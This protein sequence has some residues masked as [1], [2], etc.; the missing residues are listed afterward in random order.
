M[1]KESALR[2]GKQLLTAVMSKSSQLCV[3]TAPPPEG[4]LSVVH[5]TDD[6]MNFLEPLEVTDTHVVVTVSHFSAFGIVKSF[7]QRL[8][9]SN[10]M[11]PVGGQVL[12]FLGQPN[13]KTQRQKLN[14]FLLPGNIHLDEVKL[15]V[16]AVSPNLS[17]EEDLTSM[18]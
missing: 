16:T 11:R 14:V 5:I 13:S 12:L 15:R 3:F 10:D 8:L 17:L 9:N 7:F 2:S 18:S 4:L 6:G 1:Y